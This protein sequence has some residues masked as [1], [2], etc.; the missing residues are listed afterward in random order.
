MAENGRKYIV[1][2]DGSGDSEKE[3]GLASVLRVGGGDSG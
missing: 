3:K 1:E 2:E